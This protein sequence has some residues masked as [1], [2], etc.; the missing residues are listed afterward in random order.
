MRK[1]SRLFFER[2][3]LF[4]FSFLLKRIKYDEE[5]LHEVVKLLD[6]GTVVHIFQ[7]YSLLDAF[8]LKAFMKSRGM[9][10]PMIVIHPW[11]ER[12]KNY[13][14]G[15]GMLFLFRN[16]DP[17]PAP[18]PDTSQPG[19][20]YIIFLKRRP[21]L[22]EQG[23]NLLEHSQIKDLIIRQHG[24]EFPIYLV[25]QII[26]WN[27]FPLKAGSGSI[28]DYLFGNNL[29]PGRIRKLLIFLRNMNT[30]FART[31]EPINL[32]ERIEQ[33]E[34]K[35]ATEL[36]REIRMEIFRF[37]AEE[38]A[39]TAGPIARPRAYVLES[40]LNS[41][42]VQEVLQRRAVEENRPIEE[43][44]AEAAAILD[45]IASDM[46]PS[47]IKMFNLA[48]KYGFSKLFGGIFIPEHEMERLRN[49][50]KEGPVVFI[51][52][53]KSHVDYLMWSWVM[54]QFN[55]YPPLIVAGEN[56]DFWP[57]GRIFRKSGALFIRRTF[58]GDWFYTAILKAYIKKMFWEGY[59]QEFYI[60]G[61]RSRTGKLL[62]PKLG[63]LRVYVETFLDNPDRDIRI[64]P[65]SITYERLIEERSYERELKGAAKEKESLKSLLGIRKVLKSRYGNIYLHLGEIIS[66]KE[67]FASKGIDPYQHISSQQLKEIIRDL[68]FHTIAHI[69]AATTITPSAL[70]SMVMLSNPKKGISHRE[71][72]SKAEELLNYLRGIGAHISP[73]LEESTLSITDTLQLLEKEKLIKSENFE[74]ETIYIVEESGRLRLGF[75]RNTILHFFIPICIG[76]AA[77]LSFKSDRVRDQVLRERG[78]ALSR[79][80]RFEFVFNPE[81]PFEET[82]KETKKFLT[83]K[84]VLEEDGEFVVMKGESAKET[85]SMYAL[86]ILP[87][88]ESYWIAAKNLHLLLD[89][90]MPEKEFIKRVL[91]NAKKAHLLGEA[92]FSESQNKLNITNAVQYF[93]YKGVL[94]KEYKYENTNIEQLP[95]EY[96]RNRKKM[97]KIAKKSIAYLS[98]YEEFRSPDKLNLLAGEIKR[99]LV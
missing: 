74:D 86:M 56:L 24:Q 14:K 4:L 57:I 76:S 18:V 40:V 17:P 31:G 30:A 27:K 20:H 13:L 41:S 26:I 69:N 72:L 39:A 48:L 95:A 83:E 70:V 99:F 59:S 15:L 25:P 38:R 80:F 9:P 44:R 52:S 63:I 50:L 2:I 81:K 19:G 79:M 29:A 91:Q 22:F 77:Y 78:K 47:Y 16:Y 1:H 51:P 8:T 34:D 45:K 82:Y 87:F 28:I 73:V 35:N 54:Y 88:I 53:H 96:F 64:Q 67:F 65:I 90:D 49:V 93:V 33:N 62:M 46:S 84:N 92:K 61:G 68:A 75:Y 36:G 32:K 7:L 89:G 58:R 71:I 98:V 23:V 55:M 12:M 66:F 94:L 3:V 85:L 37:F 97:K 10:E 11:W 60:E 21:A 43:V 6:E 42:E 5:K